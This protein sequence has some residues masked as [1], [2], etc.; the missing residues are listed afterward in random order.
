LQWFAPWNDDA[1]PAVAKRDDDL[2]KM[3]NG[4]QCYRDLPDACII[5]NGNVYIPGGEAMETL[6]AYMTFRARRSPKLTFMYSP[7]SNG[8]VKYQTREVFG[9]LDEDA[10]LAHML[11]GSGLT[12]N[13]ERGQDERLHIYVHPPGPRR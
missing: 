4:W 2:L 13:V 9:R 6:G 12:F 11:Y 10:T 3:P 5:S 7:R 8:S 1:T